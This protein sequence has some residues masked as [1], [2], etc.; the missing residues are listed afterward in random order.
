M[1]KTHINTVLAAVFTVAC[2]TVFF[3]GIIVSADTEGYIHPETGESITRAEMVI[4]LREQASEIQE[5]IDSMTEAADEEQSREETITLLHEE[6]ERASERITALSKRQAKYAAER[7]RKIEDLQEE[8]ETVRG[9]IA[10]ELFVQDTPI[11]VL[12]VGDSGPRVTAL[13]AFLNW[14]GFSVAMSG[15]GSAG[16]ET[17][18]FGPLTA[19]ALSAFQEAHGIEA[20]GSLDRPTREL[21][22]RMQ[23]GITRVSLLPG[24]P[25]FYRHPETGKPVTK[26]V[27][28]QHLTSEIKNAE[29]RVVALRVQR[30]SDYAVGG[31]ISDRD[32]YLRRSLDDIRAA[33]RL[34]KLAPN[35]RR[36]S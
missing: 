14:S 26:K 18:Y 36:S 20:T 11:S 32:A 34:R 21:V 27:M 23:G 7:E 17:S 31:A 10:E 24:S 35:D 4:Y 33:P 25:E 22:L 16:N 29:D 28:I 6:I 13:Q 2:I 8:I 30:E 12:S 9:E 5:R 15:P 1:S 3:T 19:R